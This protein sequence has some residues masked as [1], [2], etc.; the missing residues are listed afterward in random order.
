MI[1]YKDGY[2]FFHREWPSQWHKT[3]FR[4][5]NIT[6]NCCE[7]WMMFNKAILF[8]DYTNAKLIITTDS[9]STQKKLGRAVMAFNQGVWDRVCKKIVYYGNYLRFTQNPNDGQRLISTSPS[10]LVEASPKDNIWGKYRDWE[11]DRKSTRLNSSHSAKS[12][13][14][15]SA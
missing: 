3:H 4:Y 14:P 12:R 7:Q 10:K 2:A 5:Q 15:S 6:F 8:G 11:T 1:Y 9:P 13:M